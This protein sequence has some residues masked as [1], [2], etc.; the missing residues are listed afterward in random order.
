MPNAYSNCLLHFKSKLL[1]QVNTTMLTTVI[2]KETIQLLH[3]Y[4]PKLFNPTEDETLT[5]KCDPHV[6]SLIVEFVKGK[7]V[8]YNINSYEIYCDVN[9]ILNQY[10]LKPLVAQFSNYLPFYMVQIGHK[11]F[12]ISK[13]LLTED[14]GLQFDWMANSSLPNISPSIFNQLY[15]LLIESSGNPQ[16]ERETIANRDILIEYCQY[17]KFH[18]LKQQLIK[19][20]IVLNPYDDNLSEIQIKLSSLVESN[21]TLKHGRNLVTNACTSSCNVQP[22][23]D[24]NLISSSSSSEEDTDHLDQP[25][26]KKQKTKSC[27]V[28][29]SWDIIKYARPYGVDT[30]LNELVFQLDDNESSLVF[31]KSSKMIHIDIIGNTL[32]QFENKFQS[33]FKREDINLNKFKFKFAKQKNGQELEH[34]ILPACISICDLTVNSIPCRNIGQWVNE[35]TQTERIIDFTNMKALSFTHGLVLNLNQSMWKCGVKDGKIMMIAIKA[36][37]FTNI[38]EFNKLTQFI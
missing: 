22:N 16:F 19:A 26:S 24:S 11:D 2:D 3:K 7:D 18:K 15:E 4:N 12:K 27:S 23:I 8:S 35:S 13:S 31:N 20:K 17:F 25:P 10:E 6:F 29:K 28:K 9:S 34:L 14:N 38:K 5:L 21:T 37:A 32:R 36:N 33:I 30:T 1:K